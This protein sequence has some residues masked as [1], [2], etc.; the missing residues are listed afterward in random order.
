[1]G[2]AWLARGRQD[3]QP[4][5]FR[6]M[7]GWGG[8]T[9]LCGD[10]AW[11]LPSS[12]P[13]ASPPGPCPAPLHQPGPSDRHGPPGCPRRCWP[14]GR[15]WTSLSSCAKTCGWLYSKSRWTASAPITRWV[16]AQLPD[17]RRRSKAR[18]QEDNPRGETA[19]GPVREGPPKAGRQHPRGPSHSPTWGFC[20]PSEGS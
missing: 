16:C 6:A 14:S 2:T 8:H 9:P 3:P 7:P 4:G 12:L 13:W 5:P 17:G 15:S 20:Q 11:L 19:A 18:V 1:M 10:P